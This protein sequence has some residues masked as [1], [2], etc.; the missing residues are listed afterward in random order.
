[1][2]ATW[3]RWGPSPPYGETATRPM[4]MVWAQGGRAPWTWPG[5]VGVMAD[6]C[7]RGRLWLSRRN[8]GGIRAE[9][10]GPLSRVIRT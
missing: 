6:P 9:E 5:G 10:Q 1:M 2:G 8:R 7:E 4:A 3:P